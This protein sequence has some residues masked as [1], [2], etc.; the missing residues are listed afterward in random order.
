MNISGLAPNGNAAIAYA[1]KLKWGPGSD[2]V[3]EHGGDMEL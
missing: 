3:Q 1:S 2:E